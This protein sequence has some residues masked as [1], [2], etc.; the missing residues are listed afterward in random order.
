MPCRALATD[1]LSCDPTVMRAYKRVIDDGYA[2][3]FAD[4]LRIEAQAAK[5]HAK[6]LTPEVLATRRASVQDRGRAQTKE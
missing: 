5:A 6:T 3:T 4:G 2:A 1:M